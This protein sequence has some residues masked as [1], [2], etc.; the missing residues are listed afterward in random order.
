MDRLINRLWVRMTSIVLVIQAVLLP[1]VFFGLLVIVQRSHAHIF[2]TQVQ[3][4]GRL[5]ADELRLG[6][7]LESPERTLKLLDSIIQSGSGVYAEV[8]E[9]PKSLRSTLVARDVGGYPRD[10]FEFGDFDDRIYFMSL[11]IAHEGRQV[12]LRLGFDENPTWDQILNARNRILYALLAFAVVSV[13]LAIWLATRIAQPMIHLQNAARRI[14]TGNFEAHLDAP[15]TIYEVKELARDLESMRSELVGT[16]ARLL[17]EMLERASADSQRHALEVRLQQR[18]RIA[19]VGTLAGGIAH[20]FNNILT[21]ILL[22][23][24]TALAE[25]GPASAVAADLA[26]VIAAAHRAR[27]LVNRVLTFSRKIETSKTTM[28]RIEPIIDEVL[29]LL[30]AII[31]P[32]I[33]IVGSAVEEV[34]AIVGDAGLI[35]QLIMN[36]CTNAYQAMRATGGRLTVTLTRPGQ[37]NDDRVPAGDYVVLAVADTG[38]GMDAKTKARIFEPFFSTREVGEGT[39]LGLSV[40]QGIATSIGATIVVDSA[41]G[42][43]ASFRVY[44]SLTI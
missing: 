22:Y 6:D 11:P 10:D 17:R 26:R 7:A 1:L 44:F 30:R 35:H 43:G 38:H 36:L 37:V 28:V 9:G 23:T 29:A 16:N 19:T 33:D 25:L 21:P 27:T 32:N 5:L 18:E 40:A 39:G 24:Q 3:T 41:P 31:P 4:Y 2:I 34:P 42:A 8:V 14:A 13:A 12:V 15:S 20:E